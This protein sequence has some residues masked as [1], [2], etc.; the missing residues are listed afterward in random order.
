MDF[1]LTGIQAAWQ[2]KGAAFGR[3]VALDALRLRSGHPVLRYAQDALRLPKGEGESGGAVAAGVVMGAAR[4]GLLDA[5]ADVLA[6]A[7]A[8][9]AMARESPAA[10]VIFALHS[11]TAL[12]VAG[13]DRFSL[14]FRGDAVAAVGLSSDDVPLEQGGRLSG[15]APWVAPIT[16]RGVAVV[17]PRRDGERAAYAVALDA[18]GVTVEPVRTAGLSGLVCGHVAFDGAECE[19][20]GATLPI[21]T[22]IRIFM[23]AAGLGIGRRALREAL[24]TARAAHTAAAGE[25]TVQGLLA[26]AATELDAAMLMTWKAA[27][28]AAD[29]SRWRMPRWRSSRP[30]RRAARRGKSDAGGGR[31]QLP[32]RAYHRAARAGRARA[33]AVCGTD[34][35]AARGGA[36]DTARPCKGDACVAPRRHR[37]IEALSRTGSGSVPPA[38]PAELARRPVFEGRYGCAIAYRYLYPRRKI[39]LSTSAG[40]ASNPSSSVFF[41][42]TSNVGPDLMHDRRAF[43]AGEVDASLR[44]DRRREDVR[45]AVEPLVLV[46]RLARSWRR[47]PTGCRSWS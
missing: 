30:R 33:G 25:Q 42:S 8:V 3:E 2:E 18:P 43:A 38:V 29:A 7:A 11:G 31:R 23:A 22:R 47:T 15:R 9:E 26:D 35:S 28:T 37:D 32:E 44:R 27:G 13:D 1:N 17:G 6:V 41:A 19:P 34:G 5:S 45:Q 36:E 14:L 4:A 21:M 16:D 20:I 39:S 24:T 10:A 46:V 40:D 12:A